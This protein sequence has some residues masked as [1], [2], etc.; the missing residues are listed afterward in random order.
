M[1]LGFLLIL[2]LWEHHQPLCIH[3]KFLGNHLHKPVNPIINRQNILYFRTEF[4][5]TTF[6]LQHFPNLIPLNWNILLISLH[7]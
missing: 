2:G 4:K 6:S 3:C 7:Q 1:L 5:S